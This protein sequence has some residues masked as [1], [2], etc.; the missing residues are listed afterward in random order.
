MCGV[1]GVCVHD[2]WSIYGMYEYMWDM[3]GT[4]DGAYGVYVM[5]RYT[6]GYVC[7]DV[8]RIYRVCGVH[9]CM[10]VYGVCGRHGC[11]KAPRCWS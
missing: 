8:H 9:R 1:C 5:Y 11:L 2:A 10:D 4:W 6:M 3:S 7:T